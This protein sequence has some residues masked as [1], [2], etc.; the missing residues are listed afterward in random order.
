MNALTAPECKQVSDADSGRNAEDGLDP[1]L[2][3]SNARQVHH[4]FQAT[5]VQRRV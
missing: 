2:V 5:V 4:G 3:A 1:F